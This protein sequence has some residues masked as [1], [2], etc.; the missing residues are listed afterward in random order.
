MTKRMTTISVKVPVPLAARLAA[1]AAHRRV[2]KSRLLRDALEAALDGRR[3]R[4]PR[5]FAAIAGDLVG[6]VTG[7][8]DLSSNPRHLRGFGR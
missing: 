2:K 4:R 8:T 6:C 3:T 5:S 1:A 7:P